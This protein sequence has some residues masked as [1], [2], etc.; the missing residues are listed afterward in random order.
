M[1]VGEDDDL[2]A[3]LQIEAVRDEVVA[4]ARVPRDDDLLRRDAEEL[5]EPQ[6]AWPPSTWCISSRTAG[7]G[8][9][10]MR[11]VCSESAGARTAAT[12][13]GWPR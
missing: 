11:R 10:S 1:V 3:R 7:D 5:G 9:A 4:L 2:V 12:G 6:R 13:T 8:V